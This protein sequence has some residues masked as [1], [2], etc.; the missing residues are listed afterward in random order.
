[1]SNRKLLTILFIITIGIRIPAIFLFRDKTL[2]HEFAVLVH[3]LRAGNGYSFF[4]VDNDGQ[5]TQDINIDPVYAIPTATIPPVYPLF[6]FAVYAVFGDSIN[7]VLWIELLQV[8]LSGISCAIIYHLVSLT[9]KR[10]VALFSGILFAVYPMFIY[11]PGQ[12][13][14]ANVYIL[15]NLALM[16]CLIKG[17]NAQ[18]TGLFYC[19]GILYGILLLSRTQ[20][21]VYLPFIVLWIFLYVRE[22]MLHRVGVFLVMALIVLA[23]W[24]YRNYR[25]FNTLVPLTTQSGYNLWQGQN[26]DATG[27]RS[28]YTDPSFHIRSEVEQKIL[29]LT[30]NDK[31]EIALQNIYMHEA[32]TFIKENPGHVV[33]LGLKKCMFYW[34]YYWGVNFTYPGARSPLYWLPWFIVLPFFIIGLIYSFIEAKKYVLFFIY[35]IVS[36]AII[37]V[38]FVIPRYRLF[39][40]PLVFPFAVSGMEFAFLHIRRLVTRR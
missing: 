36:T 30:P 39:I 15:I 25:V 14:S 35:F 3:N 24:M 32:F 22:H 38:F 26:P 16:Y 33:V 11:L 4:T 31:Y 34:G 29:A 12:I 21:I 37:M 28:Q 19:A 18:E 13:S 40:L 9:F 6:L 17:K 10:K 2:E 20:T 8:F 23:P 1:L 7:T 27:T 5:I